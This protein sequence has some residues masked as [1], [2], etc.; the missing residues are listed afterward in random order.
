MS[1]KTVHKPVLL[2]EVISG[3]DLKPGD[4]VFDG[5]LGGGGYSSAIIKKISPGGF[6]VAVDSDSKAI[7][8]TRHHLENLSKNLAVN[9]ELFNDNFRHVDNLLISSGVEGLNGAVLDLGLSSDQLEHSGRGF[10]M[11]KDEMLEM[12]MSQLNSLTAMDIV[13]TW[14]EDQL[15][16][17]FSDYGEE[18]FAERITRA[19]T[20]R[21]KI[22]AIKK[23]TEL[24]EIIKKAT[25]E[26]YHHRKI[27]PATKTFQ[28]LRIAVNDEL[29][30]L[31]EFLSKIPSVARPGGR[32][33]IVS[34]HSL[35]DR[36]VKLQFIAWERSSIAKRINKKAIKPTRREILSNR[37]SRSAK[38]RIC[39]FI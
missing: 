22:G 20:E 18:Q 24:V 11:L 8:M 32:L 6:L 15:K 26:W 16:E 2:Q 27:H 1:H 36:L 5:T 30:A 28:A 35:E 23:T 4:A 21:R 17:I 37:R 39:E 13:N 3:L 31:R 10:S 34:F 12:N 38:L 29:G 25:P 9:L 7:E 19:I 33:A 14:S